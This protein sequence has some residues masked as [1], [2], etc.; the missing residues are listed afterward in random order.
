M[1]RMLT[2][3]MVLFAAVM[4]LNVSGAFAGCGMCPTSGKSAAVSAPST[5]N[6]EGSG[7]DSDETADAEGDTEASEEAADSAA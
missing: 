1:K 6:T 4:M 3:L 7:T 5:G 2:I